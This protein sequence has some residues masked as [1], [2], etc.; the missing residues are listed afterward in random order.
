MQES[1]Y[2]PDKIRLSRYDMS[3][4]DQAISYID[5]YFRNTLSAEQLSLE[6]GLNIKK[7]RAGIR[8][9]T[10]HALHEY[11]FK[12]RIDKAKTL[13]LQSGR[14]LKYIASA[15]GFKNESH[16][17]QKFRKFV[18]MTPNEF[19]YISEGEACSIAE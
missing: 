2:I 12:V 6:T 4:I 1:M 10:G 16:F 7:L 5:K 13:L 14:P 17:C 3:C 8:K 19:R 11:H 18:S 9:K 15:V